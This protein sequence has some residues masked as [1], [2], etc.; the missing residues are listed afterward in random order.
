MTS[1]RLFHDFLKHIAVLLS[2]LTITACLSAADP[3]S[4]KRAIDVPADSVENAIK[5]LFQQTGVNILVPTNVIRDL[6]SKPVKGD[7]TARE[8]LEIMLA[9]TGLVVE[10]TAKG[11]ALTVRHA[12]TAPGTKKKT[13]AQTA[14][15]TGRVV[16]IASDAYLHNAEVRVAGTERYVYT[17]EDGSYAIEAPAGPVA[18][19]ASYSGVESRTN[20]ITATAGASNILNFDLQPIIVS[21]SASDVTGPVVALDRFVVSEDREGQAKAIMDE[22]AAP[23]AVTL[24][25]ADNFGDVTMGAVGE[26]LKYMPGITLEYGD[27]D[28]TGVRIGGLDSKYTTA[29]LDGVAISTSGRAVDLT[30][31]TSTG[32][33]TIE[34]VQT[35]TASMDAGAAAG[36]I[37]FRS[38]NPF[39]RRGTQIRYQFGLNGHSS[40]INWGG[41][42]LPDDRKHNLVFPSWQINYGGVFFRRRLAVDFNL[43]Y[44][45]TYNL[46][47]QHVTTY[48]YLN[49]NPAAN[50]QY[51]YL[52]HEPVIVNLSWRPLVQ[53]L[54]RYGANLNLGYKISPFL[55]VSMRGG[56]YHEDRESYSL[57][58]ALRAYNNTASSLDRRYSPTASVDRINS[59]LTHWVVNNLGSTETRLFNSYVHR[60]HSTLTRFATP[61]LTYKRGS[62]SADLHGGYANTLK[63]YRDNEKGFFYASNSYVSN[64]G[65]VA[66]RPSSDSPTWTLRQTSG[67]PWGN[68]EN[69]SKRNYSNLG[70]RSYPSRSE[71][72]QYVGGLDLSY[73]VPI[74]GVPVTFQTGGHFRRNTYDNWNKN[75]GYNYL[76]P[77]GRPQEA[78]IPHTSNYVFDF[79]LGGKGGNISEQGWRIDD[80]YALYD[81]FR[82]HPDWFTGTVANLRGEFTNRRHLVEDI[83]AAYFE[84]NTRINRLRLNFGGRFE[85]TEVETLTVPRRTSAEVTA[86]GYPLNAS[87]NATTEEGIRYQYHYGERIKRRNSYGNGFFSGGL[88]YDITRNLQAQLSASQSIMRPD[89]AN[90]SGT[91]NYDEERSTGTIPNATLKPEYMTKVF[92][93][94]NWRLEPAGTLSLQAYRMDI[95]NKQIRNIEISRA[96]AERIVGYPL[97]DTDDEESD[98]SETVAP[99]A[100]PEETV[101]VDNTSDTAFYTTINSR[102][103]LAVYGMTLQYNQQLTFLP[104]YLKGLSVFSS[105]T[106]SDIHGAQTDEEK[107]GQVRKSAN[108][109]IRYRVGRVRLQLRG[110]WNDTTL[111]SVTRPAGIRN[112][113][114]ND[115][116]YLKGRFIMDLSGGF[117]LTR[118]CELSFSVRNIT[119]SPAIIYSNVPDRLAAYTLRGSYWNVS[120]KGSF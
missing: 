47:Q 68:P 17:G 3:V 24:I 120:L 50:P 25:S 10:Q 72:E 77:T 69:W 11:G 29:A 23:N 76:G 73:A 100:D 103:R 118:R 86:A 109:G 119:N 113:F 39:S 6:R 41:S 38:K 93:G 8:A 42:Y 14:T 44:N 1:R 90:L 101:T 70:I 59:T 85:E 96:E 53:L 46:V 56:F 87:G 32:I 78:P 36:R 21:P 95:K 27:A 20:R 71:T 43:S 74:F 2:F 104:G 45:G 112:Y 116:R 35:L 99:P 107:I 28:A 64:I 57:T 18:L 61:R 4:E 98:G 84:V 66:D 81:I 34:F 63:R 106:W 60:Q 79:P 111:Y 12:N 115:H 37:N 108:G 48:S 33:E 16:N 55:T 22:R 102:N 91:V 110:T 75:I 117:R 97:G 89:Y 13:L 105:V 51:D 62:F 5:T 82:E 40:A 9:D 52:D 19:I 80:T 49:P 58:T 88:K 31:I 83:S 94:L 114:L 54:D 7:Y 15:I 65:W 26:I 67:D 30:D 92:A